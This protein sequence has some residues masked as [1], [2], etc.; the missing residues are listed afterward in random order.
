MDKLLTFIIKT[1]TGSDDFS[2]NENED[3]GRVVYNVDANPEIVGLIIGKEGKT[4][5]NIRRLLAIAA[6]RD[7]KSV[8]IDV[9]EKA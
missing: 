9:S 1:I 5:K 6:V 3:D 4:I 8:Q 7:N 2:I